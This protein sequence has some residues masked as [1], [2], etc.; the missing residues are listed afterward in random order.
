MKTLLKRI[1]EV[2]VDPADASK[3]AKELS[4][5]EADSV[6]GGKD[7]CSCSCSC[8][9]NDGDGGKNTTMLNVFAG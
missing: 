9:N 6:K 2:N 5:K 7:G 8:P 1:T 3:E 4:P